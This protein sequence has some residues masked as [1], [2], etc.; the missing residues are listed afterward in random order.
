MAAPALISTHNISSDARAALSRDVREGLTRAGQKELPSKYLYDE[1]GSALFEAICLLPEYGLNRAGGRLMQRHAETIVRSLPRPVV[2]AELGS[3]NGTNTRWLLEA[4]A[5]REAVRYF[6][7]DISPLA[8]SRC[9]Q[10]LGQMDSVSLV[11]LERAYLDG[12][13]EVAARR[14]PGECL[15]VLFLGGTIG[16]FDRP[17]AAAFLSQVRRIL[18]P[19]DVLL[20][21]ADLEKSVPQL[22]QAYDDPTGVTA[23]FNLNLLARIN[24]ELGANFALAQFRHL[25]RWQQDERRIEMHLQ[26]QIKQLVHIPG[27]ACD[28]SF[29]ESETIWTESSHR[30]NAS[31]L[32]K[33]A[34][35]AGYSCQAQ[36]IDHE[37]PF[38]YSLLVAA[39]PVRE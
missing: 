31:E 7:I 35:T 1:L 26:S 18:Q 6:P 5:R 38:A 11:G 9:W 25:V 22:L 20:L 30:Y 2:V 19:G 14:G 15:L 4:L 16:N 12:L 10:E 33:L 17:A 27:A 34:S 32:I 21:A 39:E 8:L 29:E 3:G 13:A 37:W 28:V 24:R 36:W 23:A